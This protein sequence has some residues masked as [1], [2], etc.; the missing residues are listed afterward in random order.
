MSFKLTGVTGAANRLN[1]VSLNFQGDTFKV[2]E[3]ETSAIAELS[4]REFVPIDK[5]VLH[6]SIKT[7]K[8]KKSTL[9]NIFASVV[10]GGIA[11]AYALAVHETPSQHD[12]PT[13][14][15]KTVEFTRGGPK[16]I[17]RAMMAKVQ[18]MNIRVAKGLRFRL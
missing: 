14:V 7:T 4:Q 8:A 1:R 6:D 10:A 18:G 3:S 9:G 5:R 2:V 13:W 16:Y 17:W 15:G 12:P 11:K